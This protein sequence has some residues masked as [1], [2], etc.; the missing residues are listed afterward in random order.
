MMSEEHVALTRRK[1]EL[2]RPYLIA[3]LTRTAAPVRIR[4]FLSP[5]VQIAAIC[6]IKTAGFWAE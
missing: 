5:S 1:T 3:E 2:A 4:A 6:L